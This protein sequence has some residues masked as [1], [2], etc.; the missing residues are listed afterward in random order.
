MNGIQKYK[1]VQ[2]MT[3]DR[4]RLVIMLYDGILRFNAAAQKA[5]TDGDI[6]SRSYNINRSLAIVTELCSSLDMEKG[7]EIADNLF[8]LYQYGIERLNDANMKNSS[9]SIQIFTGII[10]ELK[11]GWEA[12]SV[13]KTDLPIVNAPETRRSISYGV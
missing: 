7:G 11:L 13:A 8:H 3:A 9:A 4:V 2:V 5:I 1:N 12:I 6:E 10:A